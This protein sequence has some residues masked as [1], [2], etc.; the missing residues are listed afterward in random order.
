MSHFS[1]ILT[2]LSSQVGF[3]LLNC[4]KTMVYSKSGSFLWNHHKKTPH[5]LFCQKL[6]NKCNK[7][8]IKCGKFN[9]FLCLFNKVLLLLCYIQ[10]YFQRTYK[11]SHPAKIRP[12]EP[13]SESSN[14]YIL[15]QNR[16]SVRH[17]S[18]IRIFFPLMK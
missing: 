12:K 10:V 8:Q 14:S 15:I 2:F 17:F 5:L 4:K 13:N 18:S 3:F 7:L 1:A 16:T 9:Y 6:Q 11:E